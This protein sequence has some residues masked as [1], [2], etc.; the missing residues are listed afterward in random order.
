LFVESPLRNVI[1]VVEPVAT[2]VVVNNSQV[3][4]PE[5][6]LEFVYPTLE[7]PLMLRSTVEGVE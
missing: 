6:K 2:N 7:P 1:V 5:T 3:T 4:V